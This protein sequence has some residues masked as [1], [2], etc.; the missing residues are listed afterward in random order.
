MQPYI[1]SSQIL[2]CPSESDAG[3]LPSSARF[4][5]SQ[6]G[7]RTS[8]SINGFLPRGNSKPEQGGNSPHIAAIQKPASLILLLESPSTK[9]VAGAPSS[10][11]FTEPY[12]HPHVYDP[13]T[14]LKHWD[15]RLD[16]PDDIAYER[17]LGGFNAAFL[18][19]HAKFVRWD[20]VWFRDDSVRETVVASDGTTVVTPSL[21]GMFDPRGR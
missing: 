11:P 18:D 2:R 10:E 19:G 17:H 13:P 6:T 12:F 9:Y 15:A 1:K 16:R 4:D 8:Y 20:T 3:W 5:A 7:R 21:K 14:S